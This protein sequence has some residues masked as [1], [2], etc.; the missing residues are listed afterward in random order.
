MLEREL[1]ILPYQPETS[2]RKNIKKQYFF[3]YASAKRPVSGGTSIA[4]KFELTQYHNGNYSGHK[5]LHE[6]C[7][8][9]A[10]GAIILTDCVYVGEIVCV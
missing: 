4:S 8:R 1:K 5:Q 2:I 7:K 9:E 10:I 6:L 3:M